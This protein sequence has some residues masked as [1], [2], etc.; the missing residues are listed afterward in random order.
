MSAVFAGLCLSTVSANAQCAPD[1]ASS[2]QTVTCSGN[3]PN[4]F[5]A[6]FGVDNLAINVLPAATVSDGGGPA[7][8]SVND[9]NT[10]TN[11]GTLAAGSF[12][13]GISAGANNT[14]T[15][16]AAGIITVVDSGVGISA[17]G[18]NAVVTNAGAITT[19]D[20]SAG[21]DVFGDD[22]KVTSSGTITVT[23]NAAAISVQ[24]DRAVITHSGTITAGIGSAG[25]AYNGFS[26]TITNSGHIVG[27]DDT[28]GIV[29]LGDSNTI[30]NK[31][32]ITVGSGFAAGIDV[33]SFGGSNDIINTGTIN[34]GA[35]ATGILISGTGNVFNSGTINAATGF[36]AIEFCGCG[37][38]VLTLGP[39]SVINGLVLGSGTDTFQLGGTGKDTFNLSL[40]G[41]GNQYDGFSTFNKVDSSNWSVTGTG[42]QDWN[43]LG[44]TLSVN[45]TI[46]GLVTVNAGGTLGGTGTIDNV[47]VNG[48]A[49]APGNSIG[50]LNVANSLTFS[51]A[52]SYMVEISGAN[53][54]LTRVTGVAVLGGATVVVIP[55][56][57]VTKQYTILTATVG[58]PDT[59]N[60]VVAGVSPNLKASLS[61]DPNNVYL[62]FALNF[63]PPGGL[64]VNQ[65][66][67]ANTLTNFFNATGGIPVDF[68]SLTPAG[69]TQVSGELGTGS[70]QATFDAMNMFLSLMTDPFVT[71]RNG[72]FSGNASATP[73][74]GEGDANAY[75]AKKPPAPRDAFAK[76]PTKADVARNDLLDQRWSV[77]GSAFGGGSNTSGNAALGSNS[78]TARAFGFAAGAD[79]R[80]SRDTLAG[81]ALAGGGTNFSVSG[82]GSGRSDLF[83]A[84]AFVRHQMGAAYVTAAV[85]YGWQDVTTERTVTVAGFDRLRAE[86][87]ANAW[88]GRLE[89]GYRYVTPWMGITPYAAGQFTTYSLPAYAEQ[90]LSGAGTFALNYAAKDVT[91]ARTEL[92]VRTDKSFA[93]SNGVLTLRGRAA[94][95]HDF[96]TDRNVT[97]L[98]QTL[99]GAAFVVNGAAQAHDSALVTGAAEMK[100]LNGWS[101]ATIFEG[102]FSN[103]TNSYAGK[104]VVRYSW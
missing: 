46:N 43:V 97:A 96:N 93:M 68:A 77:W 94:W 92:G 101:A 75:A 95:A 88:S 8:I 16:T 21:I 80:I 4:G 59:F 49:L 41:A 29:L 87:T 37:G 70:Q 20:F 86:F 40:I 26:S 103:V 33:S 83:Q 56:G 73:F 32:T 74:A 1:P 15:N 54:D 104:G 23:D 64:N 39:G 65:Q 47:V 6:G 36:A 90:V 22:A 5:Q 28:L 63:N 72:G 81:F 89:G 51:A 34:V 12:G 69:L 14:I 18:N 25:I 76:F 91:A 52:S 44:G 60:P 9:F 38:S 53:S 31:G 11:S 58:V 13:T 24:G 27:G 10:I 84:G 62:N 78:A 71:G 48:G 17:A 2:G 7:V 61:Y 98:F 102:Q 79:Y 66:N 19:G 42:A 100:W 67:V 30:I 99:P 50:T 45:G 55:I 82:F 85:A 57:T 3:V 35:S